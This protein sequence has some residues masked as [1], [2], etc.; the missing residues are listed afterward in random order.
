MR[1]CSLMLLAALFAALALMG[2]EMELTTPTGTY[3]DGDGNPTAA[4]TQQTG[5]VFTQP[6]YAVSLDR[7]AL[8]RFYSHLIKIMEKEREM[9]RYSVN[10][11]TFALQMPATM[12]PSS[13]DA[14]ERYLTSKLEES[15]VN[16]YDFSG[17]A[18]LEVTA[19]V[20]TY[21]D[22]GVATAF[23]L[24]SDVDG[25]IAGSWKDTAKVSDNQKLVENYWTVLQPSNP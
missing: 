2:C 24:L 15:Q 7:T 23:I 16:G 17:L 9:N 3:P 20:I 5:F 10:L 19:G 8:D 25:N 12:N 21:G 14:V 11:I 18:G 1:R 6:S 22:V 4:E 13:E